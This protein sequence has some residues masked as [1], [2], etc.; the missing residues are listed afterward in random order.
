MFLDDGIIADLSGTPIAELPTVP[1]SVWPSGARV[2][3]AGEAYDYTGE[4]DL[5]AYAALSVQNR[6]LL[7]RGSSYV[8]VSAIENDI[9]PH[10]ALRLRRMGAAGGS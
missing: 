7:V 4:A 9:V 5:D 2:T 10:V 8:I 3:Q 1:V 6:R